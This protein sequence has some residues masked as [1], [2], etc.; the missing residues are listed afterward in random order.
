VLLS[1][2]TPWLI[3]PLRAFGFSL[4]MIVIGPNSF[5]IATLIRCNDG[6]VSLDKVAN[7]YPQAFGFFVSWSQPG[8]GSCPTITART[9]LSGMLNTLKTSS[10]FGRI[11]NPLVYAVMNACFIRSLIRKPFSM[12]KGL[13]DGCILSITLILS[14]RL[15][16]PSGVVI[17]SSCG[18]YISFS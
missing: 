1:R 5:V 6:G 14:R 11:V 18:L 2:R 10:A 17:I 7:A 13:H 16:S 12:R 4:S 3:H 15:C 8:Y 9:E